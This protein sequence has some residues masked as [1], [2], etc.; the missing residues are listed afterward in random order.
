MYNIFKPVLNDICNLI[1]RVLSKLPCQQINTILLVG[2]FSE[3]ALLF[4]TVK[5]S[6]PRINVSR[7]STPTYSVVK[8][9]VLCGQHEHLVKQVIGE[10]IKLTSNPPPS[11]QSKGKYLPPIVLRVMVLVL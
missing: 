4:K 6:F 10:K 1:T 2:G 8:G 3:S 9:A 7:S 5:E 11:M